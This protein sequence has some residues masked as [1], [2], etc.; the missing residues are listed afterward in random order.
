[1]YNEIVQDHYRHPRNLGRV[2]SPDGVGE[3]SVKEPS[4][5]WLQISLRLDGRRVIEARFR[6]IG[7]AATVAAGS[8]MTEWLIGRPVEA[9]L[10]LTGETVLDIL[11]GLPD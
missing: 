5:D 9:A 2:E 1:M 8:A 11:G 10:D 4:I 3:A 7:C 6:A